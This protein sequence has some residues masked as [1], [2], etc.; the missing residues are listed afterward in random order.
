MTNEKNMV[1]RCN[2]CTSRFNTN[3]LCAKG[4]GIDHVRDNVAVCANMV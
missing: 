4:G 2:D 1:Y 3:K